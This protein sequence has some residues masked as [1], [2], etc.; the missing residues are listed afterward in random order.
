M[1]EKQ[2]T[3]FVIMPI[4]DQ[5]GYDK[6]HFSRVYQH[7]IK[8]ACE[9]AGFHSIR[10]DDEVKTNYIVIDII[11]KV[12]DSD[13]VIC[14]LSAKNPNVMYELG[15]R[16]SFN[17]K[18][19]LIKDKKTNRIFDIQ[20]LRTIDYDENLR[21]DEVQKA[22]SS[23]AKTLKETYEEKENEVNSLIQLL[24]IKPAEIKSFEISQESSLIMDAL[25]DISNRLYGL[26][27]KKTNPRNLGFRLINGDK[28]F[29]GDTLYDNEMNN[30]GKLIDYHSDAIYVEDNMTVDEI[31]R[32]SEIYRGLST[33]PF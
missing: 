14:D 27:N 2:K 23:I 17:K 1:T 12:L 4:S 31:K 20:G 29:L 3:C 18:S 19:V 22:I 28:V 26:E 11:K 8:P 7:I 6:G 21:I 15:I 32:D 16:Q 5:D 33:L 30:I 24:S 13:I 10:A 9:L 25:N